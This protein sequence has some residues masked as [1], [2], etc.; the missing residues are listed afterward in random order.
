MT[1]ISPS[2]DLEQV[3]AAVQKRWGTKALRRLERA[4]AHAQGLPTGDP[5]LDA[6]LGIGLPRGALTCVSGQATSGKTTLALDMLAQVQQRDEVTVYIDTGGRLDAEYAERRG[7]SLDQLLIVCP[8]PSLLGLDIARDLMANQGAG[9]VVFDAGECSGAVDGLAVTVR[10]L[11]AAARQSAYALVCLTAS[12]SNRL[13]AA[14][15][16]SADV[17]LRVERRRWLWDTHGVSGY[18]VAT[19]VEKSRFGPPGGSVTIPIELDGPER[20]AP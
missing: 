1:T 9:L 11:L 8:Q 14:L 2:T 17:R 16:A 6:L 19:T 15:L 12:P 13:S 3:V 10:R 4:T 5:A 18:E 7:V 20:S